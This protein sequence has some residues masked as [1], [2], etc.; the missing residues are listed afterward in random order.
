MASE[1][2]APRLSLD[3]YE[4]VSYPDGVT[5]SQNSLFGFSAFLK[6]RGLPSGYETRYETMDE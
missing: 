1:A 5:Q 4:I 2:R 6:A 3:G